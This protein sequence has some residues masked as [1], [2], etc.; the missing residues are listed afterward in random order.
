M[1]HSKAS[2]S[3]AQIKRLIRL[4]AVV[5]VSP[6]RIRYAEWFKR[7]C[8]MRADA[9]ES[10]TYLFRGGGTEGLS[11]IGEKRIERLHGPMAEENAAGRSGSGKAAR[12]ACFL[13]IWTRSKNREVSKVDVRDVRDLIICKQTRYIERA[14]SG[15]SM[16]CGLQLLHSKPSPTICNERHGTS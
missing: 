5:K 7:E 3:S 13:W 12:N 8:V 11:L 10:P 6:S 4:R 1:T 9:G 2:F 16:S 14:C 15:R